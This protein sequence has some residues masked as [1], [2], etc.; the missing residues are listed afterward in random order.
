MHGF[1]PIPKPGVHVGHAPFSSAIPAAAAQSSSSKP[2]EEYAWE[3]SYERSW[4]TVTEDAEG[5]LVA[6]KT[7]RSYATGR[8]DA[9]LTAVQVC[10]SIVCAKFVA[11]LM[12]VFNAAGHAEAPICYHGCVSWHGCNGLKAIACCC[13]RWG[14]QAVYL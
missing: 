6:E 2:A 9:T 13:N 1:A 7:R 5:L 14:S 12:Y 4:E 8:V 11:P 3:R 10:P